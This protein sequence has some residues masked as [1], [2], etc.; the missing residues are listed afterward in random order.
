MNGAV[1]R[2][3]CGIIDDDIETAI[4]RDGLRHQALDV[5]HPAHVG[6]DASGFKSIGLESLSHLLHGLCAAA[7]D[8]DACTELCH[9]PGNRLTNSL[10]GTCNQSYFPLQLKETTSPRSTAHACILP[11]MN[12]QSLDD[13][14]EVPD[15]NWP[16][17][18]DTESK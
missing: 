11:I 12:G 7:T 5:I 16:G 15:P 10:A 2:I 18:V 4:G 8:D 13:S 17:D 1:D 6:G 14:P 9:S 3:G